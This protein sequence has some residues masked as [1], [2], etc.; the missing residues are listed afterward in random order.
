MKVS[1]LFLVFLL[2][3]FPPLSQ[4]AF[5][6][7]VDSQGV[8]HFTD[9]HD[10]IPAKYRS[11]ARKLEIADEPASA[12]ASTP[13]PR[14]PEPSVAPAQPADYGGQSEDWWRGRFK[15][16]RGELKTLE[17]AQAAKQSK[18]VELKRKRVIYMRAQDR[19]AI[20]S[21]QAE[22]STNELHV[23]ELQTQLADLERRATQ[24]GVPSEW[25]Q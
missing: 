24:A 13:A 20:N 17:D 22:I 23:S 16:L 25:R 1:L 4:A 15:A 8:T 21:M 14:A 10:S 18:L 5:Y 19:E 3:A 6:E 2:T 12:P 9:N 7:W 11:K